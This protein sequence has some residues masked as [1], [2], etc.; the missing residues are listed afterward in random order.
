MMNQYS[1]PMQQRVLSSAATGFCP[2][3]GPFFG[4]AGSEGSIRTRIRL[5][6]LARKPAGMIRALVDRQEV[7]AIL[8]SSCHF[9]PRA[10][11]FQAAVA[12]TI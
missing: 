3:S 7:Q 12:V 6:V 2:H 1:V 9:R 8:E 4:E 10:T 5:Q 11:R